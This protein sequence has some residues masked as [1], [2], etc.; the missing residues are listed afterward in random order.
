MKIVRLCQPIASKKKQNKSINGHYT[1]VAK[2]NS[3]S[4]HALVCNKEQK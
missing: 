1:S 2:I 4:M 3:Q